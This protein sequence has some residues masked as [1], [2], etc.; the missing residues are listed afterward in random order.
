M[1]QT[2]K[3]EVLIVDR[4]TDEKVLTDYAVLS[5]QNVTVRLLTGRARHSASLVP[6]VRSWEKQNGATRPLLVRLAPD[7]T[8]HD[9]LILVDGKT[10]WALGQSFKDLVARA[11]TTL[12]EVVGEPGAQKIAAYAD[13]WD[14]ATS[15]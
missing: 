9:R 10:A 12:V 13:M 8:L 11:H 2:A 15:L 14:T 5:P 3:S 7:K 6:A 4:Y 1:L